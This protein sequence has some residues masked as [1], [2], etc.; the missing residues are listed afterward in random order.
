MKHPPT[1]VGGF[2]RGSASQFASIFYLCGS[3][4]E[5]W[6]IGYTMTNRK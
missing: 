6:K 5:K 1:E 2:G 3:P 4:N